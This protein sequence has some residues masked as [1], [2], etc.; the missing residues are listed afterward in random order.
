M[1]LGRWVPWGGHLKKSVGGYQKNNFG[2]TIRSRVKVESI[3][4]CLGGVMGSP[5]HRWVIYSSRHSLHI[6]LKF[7]SMCFVSQCFKLAKRMTA[8][9]LISYNILS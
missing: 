2:I 5:S 9:S 8:T 3:C 1:Q 7:I 4:Y 6:V